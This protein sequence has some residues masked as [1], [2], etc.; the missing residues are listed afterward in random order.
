MQTLNK[1]YDVAIIGG[2]AAGLSAAQTLGRSR[3]SVVVI[4]AGEPRNAPADAMHNFLSRDGMNPLE[5]LEQGRAELLK[6][7]VEIIDG[8]A[9]DARR[10]ALGF[11]VTLGDGTKITARRLILAT[12]LKDQLPEIPGLAEHWGNDVLHC[13]FCHG[14]EVMDL[15]LGVIDS[16]MAVHQAT[17]FTQWSKDVTLFKDPAK[18]LGIEELEQLEALGVNIVDATVIAVLGEAGSVRGVDLSDGT[19]REIDALVIMPAFDVDLSCVGSLDLTPQEHASGLGRYVPVSEG[20]QTE[21]PGLW[22]AG[23]IVN[24]M[25]QVIMAA[26]DGVGVGMRVNGDLMLQDFA[27]A[28]TELRAQKASA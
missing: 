1:N 7:G 12:G 4:D 22:L 24:P 13:P 16:P 26:A 19:H 9:L 5:L 2:G 3:R 10:E 17:M 15:R 25:A 20:N 21:V 11:T 14:W 6:Y 8:P 27:H 23:S 28:V 18:V